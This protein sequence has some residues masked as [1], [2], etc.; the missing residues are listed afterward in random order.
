MQGIFGLYARLIRAGWRALHPGWSVQ[1]ALPAGP[2]VLLVHHQNLFGPVCAEALLRPE[3]RLWVL[4]AFSDRRSCYRQY[5]QYTFSR[6]FGWPAPAAALA[7][8]AACLAI[9]PLMHSLRAIPVCRGRREIMDTLRDS[10]CVLEKGGQVLICPDTDYA[11]DDPELGAVYTGFFH[12]EKLWRRGGHGALPFVPLYCSRLRRRLVV[13]EPLY[14]PGERPFTE[15]RGGMALRLQE[16]MNRMGRA[17]GD[18]AP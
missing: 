17:C 16:E 6:R 14:F 3:P 1:G 9:P 15:E 10:R 5:R 2:A 7:A 4:Q 8:G 18:I 13:G 12:L 11:S